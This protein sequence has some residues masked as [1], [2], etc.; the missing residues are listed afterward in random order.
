M[1]ITISDNQFEFMNNKY[2]NQVKDKR[3][4]FSHLDY[5]D[6]SKKHGANYFDRA[7]SIGM[8]EHVGYDKYDEYFQSVW[9]VL[10]PGSYFLLHYISRTD[11]HPNYFKSSRSSAC[12]GSNFIST[13]IFPNGCL[14]H[15]DWAWE[16]A[17]KIGFIK[18]HQEYYGHHYSKTLNGW[19]H[20]LVKNWP[21]L[22]K[23]NK[24]YDEKLYKLYEFYLAYCESVFRTGRA[25][26]VQQLFYKPLDVNEYKPNEWDHGITLNPNIKLLSADK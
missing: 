23:N 13:Y 3:I 1:G 26:L 9:D 10:K 24:N 25:E 5:R 7:V 16:S 2:K 14:V 12:H 21:Q 4:L 17:D 18:L 20:N 19:R 11:I 6:L 15:A 8:L 22:Q